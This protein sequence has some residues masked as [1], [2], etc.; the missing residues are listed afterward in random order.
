MRRRELIA[1]L[2]AS[3]AWPFA[4][5]AQQTGR[6]YHIGMVSPL[7]CEA[8]PSKSP[9]TLAFQEELRNLGFIKDQISRLLA[10]MLD[11]ASI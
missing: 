2:G 3:V 11:P 4:A 5:L 6:T 7:P 8:T 10:A 9:L 1:L